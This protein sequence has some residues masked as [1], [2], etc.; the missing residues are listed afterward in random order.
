MR[1]L[2]TMMLAA[3]PVAQT[4]A[5]DVMARLSEQFRACE[6]AAGASAQELQSAARALL[7]A[8][9]ALT[10]VAPLQNES[11]RADIAVHLRTV[12]AGATELAGDVGDE[13]QRWAALGRVRAGCTAC[14][15]QFR[16]NNAERG[17]FPSLG[18]TV[19]GRVRVRRAD[20]TPAPT[21]A[22]VVILE[23]EVPPPPPQRGLIVQRDRRFEPPLLAVTVGSTVVF[24]N[25]DAVFHNVF[26]LSK[27]KHFDLGLY[28]AGQNREVVFDQPG[29]VKIFCNIHPEMVA[30][31]LVLPTELFGVTTPSGFYCITGAPPGPTTV[32]AWTELGGEQRAASVLNERQSTAQD[33]AVTE[34]RQRLPHRDKNGRPYR[35]KY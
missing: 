25:R 32:R 26:S 15:L 22:A 10:T 19:H 1:L 35:E 30:N 7:A 34:M 11:E 17:L 3:A 31:V 2:A 13:R 5:N 9:P 28:G 29:L 23:A 33:F 21:V 24:P 18:A 14:H 4:A 20:G 27:A 12:E 16:D 8:L 6:H